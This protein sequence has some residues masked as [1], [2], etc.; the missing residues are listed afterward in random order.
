MTLIETRGVMM[1]KQHRIHHYSY[2]ITHLLI[3]LGIMARDEE[4]R[5]YMSIT[6]RVPKNKALTA[7]V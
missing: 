1:I 6:V 7:M 4:V 2:Q 3:K 5:R